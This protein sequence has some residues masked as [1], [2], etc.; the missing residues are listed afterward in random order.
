[1]TANPDGTS[2]DDLPESMDDSSSPEWA[3]DDHP[4]IDPRDPASH[5][6]AASLPEPPPLDV[7]ERTGDD[8][9]HGV[10]DVIELSEHVD[11]VD[12]AGPSPEFAEP[13]AFPGDREP[14]DLGTTAPFDSAAESG[15]DS[16]WD[17]PT[18]SAEPVAGPTEDV[19]TE[20]EPEPAPKTLGSHGAG[21]LS[22]A[23]SRL[24]LGRLLE[25]REDPGPSSSIPGGE[26]LET[27]PAS[28]AG[29]AGGLVRAR[30]GF[31]GFL[32]PRLHVPDLVPH[33]RFA[34]TAAIVALLF[35]LAN[36]GGLALIVLS[37]LVPVLI[38]M[39]VTQHDVFEKESNLLVAAVG[40]GG[41]VAG[42][43]LSALGAWIQGDQWFDGGILNFGAGGFSARYGEAAGSAPWLVWLMVGLVIPALAVAC[44]AGIPIALR[45]W[46]QFRNEVMDGMILTSSSAAGFAV[47]ASIVYWWP[48]I[49][50]PG[51][52]DDVS[53]WTV[54]ILGVAIVRP[55][56][57]T[58]S[59]ALIGAGIWRYMMTSSNSMAIL[60][61]IAGV[62][63]ILLVALGSIQLQTSGVWAEL[64][65]SVLVLAALF[66]VY[67]RTLDDAIATDR[68]ALGDS[69]NRVV[70]P[71]C[72]RVTPVGMYCAYC[73]ARLVD[74]P[75]APGPAPEDVETPAL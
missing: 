19:T 58:L 7:D 26:R 59:G 60:P 16:F 42:L 55:I 70:C 36:S 51:P 68:V 69:G 73:G 31:R 39:T 3:Y 18:S 29:M 67:R 23:A 48:M 28:H 14:E 9:E 75:V 46:P 34:M 2:R 62:A 1:M 8:H 43:A 15:T 64:F 54:R 50:D 13:P 37:S 41:A 61:V 17:T 33:R 10:P 49:G 52:Q 35:L 25:T 53:D 22:G 63:G 56:V 72:R 71:S 24:G 27:D 11:P 47:G 65:W 32:D 4:A 6:P 21:L 66:L 74:D 30:E 5:D 12:N 38:L 45:R 57:V 20:P 44:I 40:A